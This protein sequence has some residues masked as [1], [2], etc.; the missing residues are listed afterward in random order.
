MST[1][2]EM[3][4]HLRR[5]VP[6]TVWL[7]SVRSFHSIFLR[8]LV[9]RMTNV[10]S[11]NLRACASTLKEFEI[12]IYL[13]STSP[14]DVVVYRHEDDSVFELFKLNILLIHRRLDLT[15]QLQCRVS[16]KNVTRTTLVLRQY[17]PIHDIQE[18]L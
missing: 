6:Q 12:P 11:E 4:H 7:A 9:R 1:F 14:I 15:K 13:F 3:K 8:F 18:V 2:P 5:F 16:W 10:L 17:H